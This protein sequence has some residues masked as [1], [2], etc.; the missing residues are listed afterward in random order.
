MKFARAYEFA[1]HFCTVKLVRACEISEGIL[2][3]VMVY[4]FAI[5]L[6]TVK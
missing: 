4:E 6:G 1:I 2:T 5:R 3:L